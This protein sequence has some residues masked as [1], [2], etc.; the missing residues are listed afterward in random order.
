MFARSSVTAFGVLHALTCHVHNVI[1]IYGSNF[2]SSR[3]T[4]AEHPNTACQV[5]S[6]ECGR[7]G[8]LAM[9]THTIAIAAGSSQNRSYAYSVDTGA[10]C[11]GGNAT[12][13][14]P[15]ADSTVG[16]CTNGIGSLLPVAVIAQQKVHTVP[17][18]CLS[19][20]CGG[21]H[22]H[23]YSHVLFMPTQLALSGVQC[24]QLTCHN[25]LVHGCGFTLYQYAHNML[26][27][28]STLHCS[29][30]A[31]CCIAGA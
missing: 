24:W 18:S 14:T 2:D 16:V 10:P 23:A 30:R 13:M 15:R 12:C 27:S 3:E 9:A 29:M 17:M 4:S 11:A 25:V 19:L 7:R 31:T 22:Q 26:H 5:V 1:A 6:S 28:T 8:L 21:P 20:I